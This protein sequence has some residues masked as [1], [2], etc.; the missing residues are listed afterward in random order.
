[1]FYDLSE[2]GQRIAVLRIQHK[3]TQEQFADI[4]GIDRSY[5]SK[6][7]A[8]K[9]GLS[10]DLFIQISEHLGVSLDYL[11]VGKVATTDSTM[12]KQNVDSLIWQLNSFKS[13]L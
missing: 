1:M 6:V 12:L 7:E 10:V 9:K 8:G 3:Y 5:L 13:S 4:L 2:C 11:I